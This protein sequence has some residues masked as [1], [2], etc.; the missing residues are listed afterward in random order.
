MSVGK[1]VCPTLWAVNWGKVGL[2]TMSYDHNNAEKEKGKGK[3]NEKKQERDVYT[4]AIVPISI[5][6][7]QC[8]MCINTLIIFDNRK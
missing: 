1:T 6:E 5:V 8:K 4:I 3:W 2:H 7:V